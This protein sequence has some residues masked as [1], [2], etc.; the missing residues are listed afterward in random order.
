MASQM[1]GVR[2][3]QRG[4]GVAEWEVCSALRQSE[5][6]GSIPAERGGCGQVVSTFSSQQQG[7][8]SIL[9]RQVQVVNSLVS[10]QKVGCLRPGMPQNP[11]RERLVLYCSSVEKSNLAGLKFSQVVMELTVIT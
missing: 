6:W 7:W 10:S 1:V 2:F 4:M 9:Q 11:I 5:D 3:L 8:A